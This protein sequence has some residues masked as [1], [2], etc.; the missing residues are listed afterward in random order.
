MTLH[1]CKLLGQP[2]L[3][4][5]AVIDQRHMVVSENFWILM[6]FLRELSFF[7]CWNK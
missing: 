5:E 7:F 6:A 4:L 1:N 2:P 3:A